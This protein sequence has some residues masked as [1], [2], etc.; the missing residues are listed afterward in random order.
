[1]AIIDWTEKITFDESVRTAK[2]YKQS[3]IAGGIKIKNKIKW[4]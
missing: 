1:M 2:G 3:C 4:L